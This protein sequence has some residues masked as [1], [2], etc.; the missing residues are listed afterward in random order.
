MFLLKF[1]CTVLLSLSFALSAHGAALTT[2][3]ASPAEQ[4]RYLQLHNTLRAQYK[5][6]NLIWN[7]TLATY[8]QNYVN[9]CTWA[10]SGGPYGENLAAGYGNGYNINAAFQSWANENSTYNYNTNNPTPSHFTQVVWASTQQL[11]CAAATCN[12]AIFNG[13]LDLYIVCEYYPAGNVIGYFGSNV[14]RPGSS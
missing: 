8:A 11:G 3:N 1:A 4:A 13:A 6:P 10:H 7:D 5:A 2:R 12:L 9:K 14:L